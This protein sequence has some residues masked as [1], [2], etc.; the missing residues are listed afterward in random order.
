MSQVTEEIRSSASEIHYGNE[1]CK[2][3]SQ[4]LLSEVGLPNGLLPLKDLEECGY[5]KD[6]GF[7][8]LKQKKKSE[9]KFEKVGKVVAYAPEVTAVVEKGKIKKLSGVKTKELLMWVSVSD[10]CVD[11]AGKITF[12]TP[13]GLFRTFAASAFE[14][15]EEAEDVKNGKGGNVAANG[16][17]EVQVKEV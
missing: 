11:D 3:K 12:R 14:V 6:T 10:I 1:I 15:E 4:L 13:A 8:W 2:V 16:A 5:V 7:V 17:K 9:H